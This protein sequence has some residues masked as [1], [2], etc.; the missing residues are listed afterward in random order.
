[1]DAFPSA[2]LEFGGYNMSSASKEIADILKLGIKTESDGHNFYVTLA[3]KITNNES[4]KKIQQLAQDEIRHEAR[5]RKLYASYVGGEVGE[6]PAKGL[7]VFENAFGNKKLSEADKFRLID[8]AMEAELESARFYKKGE[9]LASE[10]ELREVFSELVAEE[11]GHYN[12]LAAERE[13]L[14]GNLSW[15]SYDDTAMMEE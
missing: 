1:V 2:H 5:L 10:K 14:R 9:G 12:L 7:T 13:S 4:K 3:Q 8:L 11:D 6:L 15:W